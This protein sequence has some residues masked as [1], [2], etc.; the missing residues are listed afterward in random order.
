MHPKQILIAGGGPVGLFCALLLG[1]AGLPVRVFDVNPDLQHDPR[2]A[3]TH[4]GTLEVLGQAG[5]VEDMARVGLVTPIFQF[6][7]R[8]TNTKIAEFDHALLKDDTNYPTVIQCEQ[9]KTARLIL[10]RLQALAN[11]EVLFNHEVV[12]VRQDAQKVSV[13]VRAPAGIT[14]H[15][16][17]YLIGAD[18]GRS[19]VRKQSGIDLRRFHLRREVSC[20]DDAVRF[21]GQSRLLPAHLFRRSGGMVQLLQGRRQ[22]AHPDFGARCFLPIPMCRKKSIL[23]DE[24]V[25]ARLMKF[26]PRAEPYDIVHRNLYVIN[27]RVADHIPQ[28]TRAA[29]RRQRSCQ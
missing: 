25:H 29:R 22:M 12:A 11:V 19:T 17:A 15:D 28:G 18:G 3:T 27:Q 8:P 13:D 14:S 23:S 5:L 21:R 6:W 4:P 26:F 1:R 9:Y 10:E 16:G 7:D 20:P 2:A 24:S